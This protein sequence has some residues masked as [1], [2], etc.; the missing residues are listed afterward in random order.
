MT[1]NAFIPGQKWINPKENQKS[2][3]KNGV[4]TP[5]VRPMKQE[6]EVEY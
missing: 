4:E 2:P 5:K 1:P 6:L 3:A